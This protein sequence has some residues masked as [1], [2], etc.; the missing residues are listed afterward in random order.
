[1]RR[2][3]LVLDRCPP[4]HDGD[5]FAETTVEFDEET[6]E[7]VKFLCRSHHLSVNTFVQAAWAILLHRLSGS[8]VDILFGAI[9][10]CRSGLA[11]ADGM[12]GLLVNVVPIRARVDPERPVIDLVR[13]LSKGQFGARRFATTPLTKIRAWSGM[14]AAQPLFDS[15]VVFEN[16]LLSTEL[17]V[18]RG[19]WP[20]GEL[21]WAYQ[22]NYPLSLFAY[23]DRK[24]R[25]TLGYD[26]RRVCDRI[27]L[28]MLRDLS[29]I[30]EGMLEAPDRAV[31][32]LPVPTGAELVA[33]LAPEDGAAALRDVD[34]SADARSI[35]RRHESFWVERLAR[36]E[37]PEVPC[38][39]P[40]GT[41]ADD[42]FELSA[43]IPAELRS[44][45]GQNRDAAAEG[46]LTALLA[47]FAR[48]TGEAGGDI[49]LRWWDPLAPG[50]EI[51]DLASKYVPLRLPQLDEQTTLTALR[52][53][54]QQELQELRRRQTYLRD[55]WSRHR[56]LTARRTFADT[57]LPIVVER[58]P[59]RCSSKAAHSGVALHVIVHPD[60]SMCRWVGNAGILESSAVE[61]MRDRFQHFLR[62]ALRADEPSLASIPIL[63]EDVRHRLRVE[64]NA[65]PSD[66]PRDARV[67]DLF[68]RQARRQP[69]ATY[70]ALDFRSSQL[71]AYLT[72]KGV[73]AGSVVALCL[74]RS[75][76]LLIG[77]LAIMKA[78]AAYLPVDVK[79]PPRRI[80]HMLEDAGSPLVL[81]QEKL[82]AALPASRAIVLEHSRD[83]IEALVP[84]AAPADADAEGLA[85]ILYTSGSS[86]RPKGVEVGH[87]ALTN[88]LC[89]M[90]RSPGFDGDDRMLAVTSIGFDIAGLE[91]YL[92]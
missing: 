83:E 50:V 2:P 36:L 87:R 39:R 21:R 38:R 47:Y 34:R 65:P 18:N 68:T 42:Y 17:Q 51:G 10:S 13:V 85:Y 73:A 56:E 80:A 69:S 7:A 22:T 45:T 57:G 81:T 26:R 58:A 40:Q 91:L 71:S 23:S 48:I 19:A 79:Y 92:P 12:L 25:L 77:L 66:Y 78:G 32:D 11:G 61:A 30:L 88:L 53:R 31:A 90:R 16:F 70:A 1:M 59:D 8:A 4:P 33:A 43:P 9:T 74:E 15:V 84:A 82:A 52:R 67:V 49:G 86:G 76:D 62:D 72:A 41:F 28:Q 14:P 54:I 3:P 89:S 29:R 63:S 60:A 55:I 5:A 24:L 44:A 46:L 6:S 64:W 37:V 75:P 27:A 20:T 35:L